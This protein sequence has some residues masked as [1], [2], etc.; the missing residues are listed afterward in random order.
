MVTFALNLFDRLHLGHE[1]MI[2]RLVE[3]PK[4]IAG[5]TSGESHSTT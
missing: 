3:M 4:P 1:V 2:D 5:V